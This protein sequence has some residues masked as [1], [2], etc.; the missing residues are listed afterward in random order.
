MALEGQA[1]ARA[2]GLPTPRPGRPVRIDGLVPSVEVHLVGIALKQP[3]TDLYHPPVSGI[4]MAGLAGALD[5]SLKVGDVVIDDC[6]PTIVPSPGIRCGTIVTAPELVSTPAQ[7]RALHE[8]SGALAVDM[9]SDKAR[10]LAE[11]LSVPFISLRAISDTASESVDPAVLRLVDPFGQ[12]QP[13]A[14]ARLLITRPAIV[15]PLR[16][17]NTASRIATARL[18]T[19][20]EEMVR[21]WSALEVAPVGGPTSPRTRELP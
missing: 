8:R 12:L 10:A 2:W 15:G 19:A 5:P 21:Q 20:V 16:H 6:P 14:L 7:K 4:M 9:E 13:L 3:P 17:L 18:T 11:K 1:V